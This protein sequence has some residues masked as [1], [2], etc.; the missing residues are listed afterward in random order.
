MSLDAAR[1]ILADHRRIG[2][3][4][5]DRFNGKKEGTLWY[6]RSLANAYRMTGARRALIYELNRVASEI[7]RSGGSIGSN[8]RLR[9]TRSWQKRRDYS[10]HLFEFLSGAG[11]WPTGRLLK[12]SAEA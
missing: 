2:E 4:L 3:S 12:W 8:N 11:T 10:L 6:Y 7:E 1:A 5:W 9:R